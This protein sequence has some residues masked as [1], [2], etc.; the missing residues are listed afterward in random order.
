MRNIT[1]K[2]IAKHAKVSS[3]T[4]SRVLNKNYYVSP[5]LTDRVLK[6]VKE[7]NYFPNSIARSLKT[8]MTYTIGLIVSDIT[9]NFF[10]E[11]AKEIGRVIIKK[12]YNLIVCSTE[13]KEGEERKY[14]ELLLG[15]KIDGL[16]L[17]TMEENVD[18]VCEISK[19]IPI[20]LLNRKIY[21]NKPFKGDFIGT[22][23]IGG[24]YILTRHLLE[25]G[26]RKIGII[27]GP[28]GVSTGRERYEGFIKAMREYDIQVNDD[29]PYRYDGNFITL[30]GYMG[31]SKLMNLPTLPTVVIAMNNNMLVGALKY[32]K[33][34]ELKIPEDISICSFGNINNIDLLY[35]K[36][37]IIEENPTKIGKDC[38][39]MILERIKKKNFLSNRMKI[40]QPKLVTGNTVSFLEE[41]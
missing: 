16:I 30:S 20:V 26:H 29:Y 25:Y 2:D 4:V 12:N 7:F 6:V 18:F 10:T 8:T 14:L 31:M 37:T 17:N 11:V 27:N 35:V 36:P 9:N 24:S 19:R 38:A 34:Y 3:A 39:K 32:C 22:D 5:K 13:S 21:N 23:C 28:L 41:N 15:K 40:Y 33:E 1:I